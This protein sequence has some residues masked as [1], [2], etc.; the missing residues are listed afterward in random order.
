MG[1]PG[2]KPATPSNLELEKRLLQVKENTLGGL[3]PFPFLPRSW[4]P[5]PSITPWLSSYI[6]S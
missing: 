4:R 6:K 2:V 5:G 1:V 3:E